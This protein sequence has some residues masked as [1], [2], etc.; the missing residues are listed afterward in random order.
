MSMIFVDS[1]FWKGDR[2]SNLETSPRYDSD[3]DSI[4]LQHWAIKWAK[5][6]IKPEASYCRPRPGTRPKKK[7]KTQVS[8][9]AI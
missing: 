2:M 4:V 9:R 5:V 6:A 8:Y 1:L 7:K 3:F